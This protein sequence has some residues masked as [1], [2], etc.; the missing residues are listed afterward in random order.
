MTNCM[1]SARI[2]REGL[3]RTGRFDIISKEKGVPLVAFSFKDKSHNSAFKLATL[4]RRYG[5]IVPAYTM[6]ANIEHMTV[7]RVVVR[8]DFGRPMAER[9][10]LHVTMALDELNSM[11]KAPLVPA[12]KYTIELVSSTDDVKEPFMVRVVPQEE[13]EKKTIPLLTG[14]TKGVC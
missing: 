3:L 10:L 12:M 14:K 1:E 4:L 2:L 11:S 9:F 7:L 13:P 5:W 6:P 8:E